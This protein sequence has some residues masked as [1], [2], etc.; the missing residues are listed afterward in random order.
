MPD[1]IVLRSRPHPTE[2]KFGDTHL[3]GGNGEINASDKKDL[4]N[5]IGH[6]VTQLSNGQVMTAA[7]Q[8]TFK[9]T[10]A[11]K[12]LAVTAAYNDHTGRTFSELGAAL[13]LEISEL[14]NRDGFM[15]RF[16]QRQDVE[17]GQFPQIRINFKT[18]VAVVASS[19]AQVQ[20]T[21]VRS[22]FLLPPEFYIVDNLM[23]EQRDITRTNSDIMEEK[24]LE[25]QEAIMVAEDRLFLKLANKL[26]GS[27]NNLVNVVGSFTPQALQALRAQIAN[28]GLP[29]TNLLFASDV[30]SDFLTSTGFST[31][32]DPVSQYE[33]IQ[34]GMLGRL[35]GM[36]LVSDAVRAPLLRVLNTGEMYIFTTPEYLG[37]YTDRGP[38]V[39]HETNGMSNGMGMPARGWY[40]ME[41]MS[42][43]VVNGKGIAKAIRS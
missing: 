5:K 26:I 11:E 31:F 41:Q 36:N 29:T 37:A 4:I 15:R 28:W 34:T 24:L 30:W 40:M 14:A 2:L 9:V 42:M 35:L 6:F 23:I 18:Q 21:M 13:A 17:Q 33:L 38:V 16:L 20:P 12:R 10:A 32:Y 39:A 8:E 19:A 27:S 43:A 7:E 22:K 3:V 25:G 1:N